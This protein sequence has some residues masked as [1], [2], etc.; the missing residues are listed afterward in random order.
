MRPRGAGALMIFARARQTLALTS[1]ESCLAPAEPVSA[2][3]RL[4]P[5]SHEMD[6]LPILR[7][8]A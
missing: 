8:Y 1:Q 4:D 5:L 3:T 6:A 2:R 7:R